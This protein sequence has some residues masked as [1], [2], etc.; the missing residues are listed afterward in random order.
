MRRNRPTRALAF[1]IQFR[2]PDYLCFSQDCHALF[3]ETLIIVLIG[4]VT[5][6]TAG[7][8]IPPTASMHIQNGRM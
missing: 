6:A 8:G 5:R 1:A 3:Q 2:L 4:A 7:T